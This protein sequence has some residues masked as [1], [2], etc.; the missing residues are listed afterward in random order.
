ME[1]AE[2]LDGD[3]MLGDRACHKTVT[4]LYFSCQGWVS[5]GVA[6]FEDSEERALLGLLI[7]YL[8]AWSGLY[9]KLQGPGDPE[10]A[11]G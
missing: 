8:G 9:A 10:M 2:V 7:M 3:L 5:S 4:G 11:G 6:A 1:L